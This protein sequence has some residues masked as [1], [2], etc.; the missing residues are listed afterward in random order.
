MLSQASLYLEL[1]S[2]NQENHG[3]AILLGALPIRSVLR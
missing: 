2:S 1:N 3:V